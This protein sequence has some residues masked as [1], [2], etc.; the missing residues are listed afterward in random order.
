[1]ILKK[2][3]MLQLRI[4]VLTLALVLLS[5][6]GFSQ[7]I[8]FSQKGVW[9]FASKDGNIVVPCSYEEVDFYSDD[10][11]AKVRK[12]EKYGYIDKNGVVVIP[13]KYDKCA[14]IY[15]VYHGDHSMGIK[16]NPDLHLN[17]DFDFDD[18]SN[19]RYVVTQRGKTGVLHLVEGKPKVLIPLKY[20]AIQFD[21]GR[22]VFHCSIGADKVYFNTSGQKM[23][24][25][26][27]ENIN[28]FMYETV[29]EMPTRNRDKPSVVRADGKVGVVRSLRTR[30]GI[31]YDTLVPVI[32]EDIITENFDDQYIPGNSVFAVKAAGKWGLVDD[33]KNVILPIKFDGINF[34]LSAKDRHWARYRRMFVVQQD[35]RWG[36]LAKEKDTSD[37]IVTLL[38][39]EYD[40]VSKIYFAYL[41]VKKG[42]KFQV[43]STETFELISTK[44]YDSISSYEYESVGPF[45]L[46]QATNK[47]GQ[48]VFLGQNGVEFF[49]D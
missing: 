23:T 40:D 17:R 9:G 15:D 29:M 20:S 14:R 33:K 45:V 42:N 44:G 1:M 25:E 43:F 48:T 10:N 2:N 28:P 41:S 30:S 38:P 12:G 3:N 32:Y 39:F 35:G 31:F 21:P 22:K 19:N 5:Y 18:I 16:K 13:F 34:D 49:S 46:F 26:Q 7:Y 27:V 36:I 24:E 47:L 6:S 8:P 4:R 11:L 37:S